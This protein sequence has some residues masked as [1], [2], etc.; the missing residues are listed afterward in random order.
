MSLTWE[1]ARQLVLERLRSIQAS[2]P[3]SEQNMPR[4]IIRQ[5]ALSINDEIREVELWTELGK[6]IATRHL[7]DM[8]YSVA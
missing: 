4:T 6:E 1:Q 7:R 8:G 2:L 5:R 3:A